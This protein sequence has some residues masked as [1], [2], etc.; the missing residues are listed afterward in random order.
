MRLGILI[1][2]AEYRDALAEKLSI[3]DN[4]LFVNIISNSTKGTS[5]SL[6]LT[7]IRP[8]E[9]DPKVLGA[10]QER[11][12]FLVDTMN[13]DFKGCH[14]VF[15][16]GSVSGLLSELSVVYYVWHGPGPGRKYSSRLL[17]VCC[18]TDAYSATG[19]S[20]LARQIVY[21]RGGKV[22][23]LPLAFINDYGTKDHYNN[24]I[25]KLLYSIHTGHERSSDCFTYTDSYG[26][27]ALILP[28]GRNP[29]A[30]IDE[31]ELKGLV[32]GLA[33]RFDTII[34]DA[35]T[36]FRNENILIMKESDHIVFFETGRR[37]LGL[38]EM[39]G[40]ETCKKLIRIKLTGEADEAIAIDD[41][42]KQIFSNANDDQ[43]KSNNNK[44]IRQ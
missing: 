3:C 18:E 14:T 40:K 39:I 19:C 42:V 6:I 37:I 7:D 5:D 23:I 43:S 27:S 4:N 2:D 35:G 25:S 13:D 29:V 36:C 28:P 41:C 24:T 10:I 34:C 17:T 9:I 16:Y 22:L 38:E 20:T 11:T 44:R 26:V 31:D 8:D 12:V 33:K 15:K 21:R 32:S 30:Y 1:R